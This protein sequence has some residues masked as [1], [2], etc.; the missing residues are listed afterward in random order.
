MPSDSWAGFSM[1]DRS[2]TVAGSNTVMSASAPM[3]SRPLRRSAGQRP[4]S[5]RAGWI[6]I[7]DSAVGRSSTPRSRTYRPSTRLKQPVDRG[8]LLWGRSRMASLPTI[9][10]SACNGSSTSSGD[11][12]NAA[13]SMLAE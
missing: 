4:S 2:L 8:W 5:R 9:T 3:P 10:K 1:V 7:F 6:V 13:V 12:A 11:M